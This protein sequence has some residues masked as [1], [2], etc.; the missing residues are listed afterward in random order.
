MMKWIIKGVT[1]QTLVP[2]HLHH[3][4]NEVKMWQLHSWKQLECEPGSG[5]PPPGGL[6]QAYRM[7]VPMVCGCGSQGGPVVLDM[8]QSADSCI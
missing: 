1:F 4:D 8:N 7:S 5:I 3:C 6:N 2:P